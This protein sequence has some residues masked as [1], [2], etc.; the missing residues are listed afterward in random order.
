MK[1]IRRKSFAVVA[2]SLGLAAVMGGSLGVVAAGVRNTTLNTGFNLVGGPLGGPVAPDQFVACIP[3]SSWSGMYIWDGATQT[4]QHYFNT[5]DGTVPGY[6]NTSGAG[7]IVNIPQLSG[8]VI[9]MKTQ[10][11]NPRLKDSNNESCG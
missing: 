3:A 1:W 5:A 6:V 4:W 8:V 10:V 7:G 11:S 2:A 9:I